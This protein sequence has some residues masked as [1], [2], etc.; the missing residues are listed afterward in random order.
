MKPISGENLPNIATYLTGFIFALSLTLLAFG[1]VIVRIAGSLEPIDKVLDIFPYGEVIT[2]KMP[3][4]IIIG[5]IIVLAILQILVHLRYFLHLSF[6]SPQ[7]W[8]LQAILFALFIIIIMVGGTLWIMND[9]NGHMLLGSPV[10]T[11]Y[12]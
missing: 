2:G 5:G 12:K 6:G 4:G 10:G 8:N 11:A 7:N 1:L 3:C 9:L